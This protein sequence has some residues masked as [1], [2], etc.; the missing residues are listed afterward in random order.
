MEPSLRKSPDSA[1]QPAPGQHRV[2]SGMTL[3]ELTVVILVLLTLVTL[4]FISG[5][6][7]KRGADRA[8]C[9]MNIELIQKA[10][11]SY[12]NL[13]C[14]NPGDTVTDLEDKI[15]GPGRFVDRAPNCP[16]GGSYTTLR[17]QI[18]QVG[19]VYMTCSLANSMD[20]KPH[21]TTD[22]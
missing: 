11:R 20:H 4:L 16:G 7:W 8:M 1:P 2:C 13:H 17:D 5:R 3:L 10:V 19:T 18:P 14:C 12:S 15:I 9:V 6:A 22:W 21:D